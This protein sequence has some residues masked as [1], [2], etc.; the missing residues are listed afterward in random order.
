MKSREGK[1]VDAYDLI[2]KVQSLVKKEL[3]KREKISKKQLEERSLKIA[4]A[5]IK[6]LLLKTDVRKDIT[7]NPRESI[8]FEGNTGPYLQYSFARANS[9]LRKAKTKKLKEGCLGEL[10]PKEA[11]LMKKMSFFPSVV[12]SSAVS[13]NPTII[14]NYAYDLAQSFNEFYHA[15]PVIN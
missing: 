9:I 6:Y 11:E 7:F 13:L 2:N 4:L 5:A 12:I 15:C 14:A 8:S 3:E 10:E 1:I